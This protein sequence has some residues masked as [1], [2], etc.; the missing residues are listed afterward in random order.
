[1]A[2]E[3]LLLDDKNEISRKKQEKTKQKT[4]EDNNDKMIRHVDNYFIF[5]YLTQRNKR[6]TKLLNHHFFDYKNR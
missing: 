6:K 4:T 3:H 1:M 5:V 2:Y